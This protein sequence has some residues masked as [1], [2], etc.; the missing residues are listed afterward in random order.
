[1]QQTDPTVRD[2]LIKTSNR[3][4]MSPYASSSSSLMA[5]GYSVISSR[6]EAPRN[7]PSWQRVRHGY[8]SRTNIHEDVS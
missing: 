3:G 1:M 8:R 7:I 6:A 2:A 4:T 5:T